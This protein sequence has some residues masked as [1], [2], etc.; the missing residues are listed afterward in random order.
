MSA[1]TLTDRIAGKAKME[2]DLTALARARRRFRAG[3]PTKIKN[4]PVSPAEAMRRAVVEFAKLQD[5][6][7]EEL[8]RKGKGDDFDPEATRAGLVY[9]TPDKKAHTGWLPSLKSNR[10]SLWAFL[11]T[12]QAL[13]GT[14]FL[15]VIFHQFDREADKPEA[16]HTFWVLQF[17]AGPFAENYLREERDKAR[18]AAALT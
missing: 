2:K 8:E 7:L 17:I 15:G 12:M 13:T 4:E 18:L 14:E 3:R 10:E 5:L 9:V 1:L 11:D 6:T 16:K